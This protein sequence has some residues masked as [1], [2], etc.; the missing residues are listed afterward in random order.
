[1][2]LTRGGLLRASRPRDSANS[3]LDRLINGGMLGDPS[4]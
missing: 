3:A 4:L 1:V 2:H